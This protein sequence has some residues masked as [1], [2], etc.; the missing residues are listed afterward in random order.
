MSA[1]RAERLGSYSM[2]ATLP[3]TP[4]LFRLKSMMRNWRL[5][6]PPRWRTVTRPWALRPAFLLRGTVRA[7]SGLCLVISSK[8]WPVAPRRPGEVGLYC[9]MPILHALE[10]LDLIARRQG[11]DG[12][13]PVRS[14]AH[15]AAPAP[16]RA[17]H[18]HHVDRHYFP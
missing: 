9:L 12:L 6:P 15:A 8:V 11:H 1:M 4:K 16:L 3:G 17:M 18:V 5:A 13:L 10:Q 7:F 2:A 14:L